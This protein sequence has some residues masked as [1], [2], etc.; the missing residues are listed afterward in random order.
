MKSSTTVA[1]ACSL[2]AHGALC[3]VMWSAGPA[4]G[5]QRRAAPARLEF[6]V[7]AAQPVAEAARPAPAAPDVRAEPVLERCLLA[8][9]API[10]AEHEPVAADGP[11]AV[12]AAARWRD[13]SMLSFATA[14]VR[15]RPQQVPVAEAPEREPDPNEAPVD[16]E[17]VAAAEPEAPAASSS[18][19]LVAGSNVP[20]D[21]PAIARRRGWQGTA[22]L[23][24]RCDAAGHVTDVH[25]LQSSGHDVLDRAAIEAV[26]AWR[27]RGGPG[28]IVQPVT[29]LLGAG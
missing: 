5:V 16:P 9:D 8:P 24:I 12:P 6:V 14:R 1:I 22:T 10:V 11:R 18:P 7:R 23:R 13:A 4:F 25:L 27:F 2:F 26:R 20:P 21:Y 17:L 19:T 28:A 15:P 3:L 29:F